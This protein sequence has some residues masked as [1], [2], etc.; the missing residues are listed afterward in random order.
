MGDL[1]RIAIDGPSGAG[2]STM[3]KL[4][5]KDLGI[6]YIDTGA[7]YRAIALK[8]FRTG[9]DCNNS[10]ALAELLRTTD[11]DFDKGIIYL[12]GE[13]V[14]AFIRTQEVSEMASVSSAIP[15]VRE[16]L[17]ALQ[18]AMAQRKSLVMDGRDITTN[19]IPNAEVKI[20]LTASAHERAIRRAAEMKEKGQPCDVDQIEKEIEIRDYRDSHREVNPLTKADDAALIDSTGNTIE[21]TVSIIKAHINN[22]IGV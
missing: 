9:T 16:K 19:V 21:E 13:D 10:E 8:L 14:S 2:K 11:V 1:L 6:D 17:V 20:F 18:K 5:A 12:D 4:L 3:A 22:I 7:M 15:A